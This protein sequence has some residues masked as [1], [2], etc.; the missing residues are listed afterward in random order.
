MRPHIACCCGTECG[1]DMDESLG[2]ASGMLSW[3]V[4]STWRLNPGSLTL[5]LTPSTPIAYEVRDWYDDIALATC[6]A[7]CGCQGYVSTVCG[8]VDISGGV[9]PAYVDIDPL[10]ENDSCAGF[11]GAV[12]P[13][14]TCGTIQTTHPPL[15]TAPLGSPPA[16]PVHQWDACYGASPFDAVAPFV[17]VRQLGTAQ[18]VYA[19]GNQRSLL[20]LQLWVAWDE[21]AHAQCPVLCLLVR[22]GGVWYVD[23]E[24]YGDQWTRDAAGYPPQPTDVDPIPYASDHVCAQYRSQFTPGQ[25]MAQWLATPMSL[26]HV[27]G[28]G[29]VWDDSG[30]AH[31]CDQA[32]T[33]GSPGVACPKCKGFV[34]GN[35]C[36]PITLTVPD[37][38]TAGDLLG[39][40][41][42][43]TIPPY[44]VLTPPEWCDPYTV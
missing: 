22:W 28:V 16:S 29:G 3:A 18:G 23:G 1:A 19:A 30:G 44:G 37:S 6:V 8:A 34:A 7:P 25:S 17:G 32:W 35:V 31:T 12:L 13:M 10:Q 9:M 42:P 39:P 27:S 38:V 15:L 26:W 41:D 2:N 24:H 21:A 33:P 4:V 36:D 11:P 20:S 14:A 43:L 40:L 5:T